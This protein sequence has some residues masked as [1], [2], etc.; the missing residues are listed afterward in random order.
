MQTNSTIIWEQMGC[1]L[2]FSKTHQGSL[3]GCAISEISSR[4]DNQKSTASGKVA[5]LKRLERRSTTF[6]KATAFTLHVAFRLVWEDCVKN[7]MDEQLH[8]KLCPRP[9]AKQ[10]V[11]SLG[12]WQLWLFGCCVNVVNLLGFRAAGKVSNEKG[13]LMLYHTKILWR[14]LG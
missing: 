1:S 4:L 3:I 7:L 13:L 11:V 5:G 10:R 6:C 14:I 2:K 9:S 12:G 8:P